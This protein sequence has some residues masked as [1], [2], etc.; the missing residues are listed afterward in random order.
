MKFSTYDN[1]ALDVLVVKAMQNVYLLS[2]LLFSSLSIAVNGQEYIAKMNPLGLIDPNDPKLH[3]GIERISK[4][5]I[6]L[7]VEAAR[8]FDYG[9]NETRTNKRGWQGSMEV[10]HY[11]FFRPRK[12]Y[13]LI[14]KFVRRSF[15][16]GEFQFI[17]NYYTL[18][19]IFGFSNTVDKIPI[20][21]KVQRILFKA[22]E[23]RYYESGLV[24]EFSYLFGLSF[25]RIIH[26][27]GNGSLEDDFL[28]RTRNEEEGSFVNPYAGINFRI[29][30]LT[31]KKESIQ[32]FY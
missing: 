29:G 20:N 21:R 22:G 18:D 11:K 25:T 32:T 24:L 3:L 13:Y 4:D 26:K 19:D 12:R 9:L 10:R 7:E 6:G 16:A 14:T 31:N 28:F 30:F 5:G 15:I 2:I 23:I 17:Q 1:K 27:E 8:Y